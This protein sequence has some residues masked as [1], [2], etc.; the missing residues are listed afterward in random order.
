[1]S[2]C[3]GAEL[4]E[5]ASRTPAAALVRIRRPLLLDRLLL[6]PLQLPMPLLL[7]LFP[8]LCL[9][10]IKPRRHWIEGLDEVDGEGRRGGDE[11]AI[12]ADDVDDDDGPTVIVAVPL[13]S[14]A[15]ILNGSATPAEEAR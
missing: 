4:P 9:A 13:L 7:A 10:S 3:A 15:A 8:L 12:V 11:K 2:T 1:M 14:R 5:P 6:L